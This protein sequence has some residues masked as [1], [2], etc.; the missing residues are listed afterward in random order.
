MRYNSKDYLI[1]LC[2]YSLLE[3]ECRRLK[4]PRGFIL[5]VYAFYCKDWIAGFVE[6]IKE[7]NR[8]IGVRIRIGDCVK[9]PRETL[10]VFFHEMFHVKEIYE[11]RKRL[12]SE[13]L[14]DLYAAK[15]LLQL[16]LSGKYQNLSLCLKVE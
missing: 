2:I 16:I 13:L 9:S 7:E 3:E 15:R 5:G 12:F 14:A 6:E 10:K 4:I 1:K 8:V 11:G